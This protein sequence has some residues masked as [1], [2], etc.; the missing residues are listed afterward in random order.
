M[1]I[2]LPFSPRHFMP[3]S[4]AEGI[5]SNINQNKW[6]VQGMFEGLL[7]YKLI[8]AP[9][10]HFSIDRLV[11]FPFLSYPSYPNCVSNVNEYYFGSNYAIKTQICVRLDFKLV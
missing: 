5:L 6:I 2:D 1:K 8:N 7:I 3:Q 4:N 11:Y 9:F 10:I